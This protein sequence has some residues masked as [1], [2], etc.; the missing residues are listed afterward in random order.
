MAAV[1]E[2]T[3]HSKKEIHPDRA[4]QFDFVAEKVENW[5][6]GLIIRDSDGKPIT[7]RIDE[8]ITNR[9]GAELDISAILVKSR[10]RNTKIVKP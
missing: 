7:L 10:F 4:P 5:N 1:V 2:V 3:C 6:P 9:C 8:V